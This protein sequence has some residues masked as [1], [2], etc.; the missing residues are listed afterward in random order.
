[1]P[2]RRRVLPLP[3]LT[4]ALVCGALIPAHATSDSTPVRWANL[5]DL[6]TRHTEDPPKYILTLAASGPTLDSPGHAFVIWSI[7]E[8]GRA[9]I[10]TAWGW[11]PD[12]RRADGKQMVRRGV[13]PG[14]FYDDIRSDA[15][16]ELT[17]LVDQSDYNRAEV[18]RATWAT[19]DQYQLLSSDCADFVLGLAK[20]LGLNIP[21]RG[22]NPFPEDAVR[23]LTSSIVAPTTVRTGNGTVYRGPTVRGRA[24]GP[25]R[26]DYPGGSAYQGM[27]RSGRP[28]GQGSFTTKDGKRFVGRWSD[29]A[30][31]GLLTV[32]TS[33]GERGTVRMNY[34]RYIG[35][36]TWR[37]SDGS[38]WDGVMD[39]D[40]NGTFRFSTPSGLDAR[41][42]FTGGRPS[43]QAT[44]RLGDRGTLVFRFED[45][46]PGTITQAVLPNGTRFTGEH[47][48]G[49]LS[50]GTL[51][52][53]DGTTYR[54]SF[55]PG[56]VGPGVWSFPGGARMEGTI[57]A[58]GDGPVTITLPDGTRYQGTLRG[59]RMQGPGSIQLPGASR[60]AGSFTDGL[61]AL[62]SPGDHGDSDRGY[63][64]P[65]ARESGDDGPRVMEMMN[66]K[67][68]EVRGTSV[69][70]LDEREGVV[71][72]GDP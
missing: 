20:D 21:G 3:L 51:T 34:G 40:G 15:T 22:T 10:N 16:T 25:G 31:D 47:R 24:H 52:A 6:R 33:R 59:N 60:R 48:P 57:N 39:S 45:G 8:P 68:G 66:I 71:T 26:A 44:A 18:F 55:A 27:F 5:V 49:G 17:L 14:A 1:M 65:D 37:R 42:R 69:H 13:V 23:A 54:G 28:D 61:L 7:V 36:P 53:P 58:A 12:G 9:P 38:G 63:G 72:A 32:T 41:G 2:A 46:R 35:L 70:E 4:A 56:R 67:D 50:R 29:G 11:Y 43:G 64:P 19:R 30:P 62:T